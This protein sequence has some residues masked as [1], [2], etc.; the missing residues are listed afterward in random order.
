MENELEVNI[1]EQPGFEIKGR[2][3]PRFHGCAIGLIVSV[4]G[5]IHFQLEMPGIQSVGDSVLSDG[6]ET[7]PALMRPAPD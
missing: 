5:E 1:V 4:I 3:I 2:D 6:R 7:V